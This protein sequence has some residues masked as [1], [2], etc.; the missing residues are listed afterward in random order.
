M[1]TA[2]TIAAALALAAGTLGAENWPQWRGPFLNGSTTETG[3]PESFSPTE[4][5]VWSVPM[6]GPS[7]STPIVWGD[8]IF[9]SSTDAAAETTLAM[10]LDAADG[11]TLW[12]YA[13]GKDRKVP[14]NNM[15]SASPIA[16]GQTVF[17]YYGT[18]WLF[19]YD[20]KGKTLW[21][22]DLETEYGHNAHMFGYSS[23]PLLFD[24][25]LY[26]TAMRNQRQDAYRQ[27]PPG[28][29][30]SYLLAL[31]PKTGKNLWKADRPT[32]ARGEAQESYGTPMPYERDGRAVILL[33]GADALTA[34][35]PAGGKELWR[36]EGYNPRRINH[37]RIIPSPVVA[38]DV[39]FVPGPKH[40]TGYAIRPAA[41]DRLGDNPIAWTLE[42]RVPDASTPLLYQ[43]RLYVL[44]D[45]RRVISCL[46]PADGT[47]KYE[48][49]IGM[50]GVIRAS[51]TG[52]DGK[53]YVLSETGEAAVLKAG[54]EFKV[55]SRSQMADDGL[56]RSSIVAAGGRLYVR[57][58]QRL[59]CIGK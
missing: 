8:R 29:A 51:V 20:F 49:E 39:I 54:D 38:G 36:W 48:Q 3:L 16:D 26:V 10:C 7:G 22:R 44:D 40:S 15:A 53:L 55:L 9:V 24:G 32:E 13:T 2:A 31:D 47:V 23:S 14:R 57:T 43:G 21:A 27:A 37:W 58:P 52:A 19:A 28:D 11:K 1:L 35:D 25:R 30:P 17:F 12:K 33:F 46:D 42:K 34:H 56:T 41:V 59:F 18:G 6:P 4:N 45:D 5:V 50:K